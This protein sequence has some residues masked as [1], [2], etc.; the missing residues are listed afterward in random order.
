M[1]LSQDENAENG[2]TGIKTELFENHIILNR[3]KG[4]VEGG[5]AEV[6]RAG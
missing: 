4:S 3:Y 1:R 6:G 5:L 2:L